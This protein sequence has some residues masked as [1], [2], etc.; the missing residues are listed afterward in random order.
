MPSMKR[1]KTGTPGVYYI[2]GQSLTGEPERIYYIRYR[3]DGKEVEEK[4]G[5]EFSDAMTPEKA[6]KIR[7][8]YRKGK[9]TPRKEV[10]Y[11]KNEEKKLR[12]SKEKQGQ[13]D[14]LYRTLVDHLLQGIIILQ[15]SRIVFANT[16]ST[17]VSGY[18]IEEQLAMPPEKLKTLVHSDDQSAAWR[19]H[20]D[21]IKRKSAPPSGD[22]YRIIRKDGTIRWTQSYASRIDYYGRP[23]AMVTFVDIT[24]Q[25]KAEGLLRKH[26]TQLKE[27]NT[28]LKVLL[29]KLEEEKKELEDKVLSNTKE[30]VLPFLEKLK[31]SPL[32]DQQK[33]LVN[34]V[35]SNLQ[36]IVSPFAKRLNSTYLNLTATEIRIANIIKQGKT[37]K[38]IADSM[39][40]SPRTIDIHRHNIR[41]K[42]GLVNKK[43][44]LAAHLMSF[45]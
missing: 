3:R 1:F 4:V 16:A 32:N 34:I 11:R 45:G 38:E 13:S 9:Q 15:D 28:A 29:K 6:G 24:E 40:I 17:A 21:R 23:A 42:L 14:Q 43:A 2:I 8:E 10:Q 25:K 20:Q 39:N 33:T 27:A 26:A 22:V 31:S 7:T 19:R 18:T 30:L 37:T 12:V 36:D 35:E 44:N 41:K 5:R